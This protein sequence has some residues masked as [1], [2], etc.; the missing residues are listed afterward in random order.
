MSVQDGQMT[1]QDGQMTI[2]GGQIC[3][4][5]CLI[6]LIIKNIGIIFL[7]IEYYLNSDDANEATTQDNHQLHSN[8]KMNL[9]S[10]PLF[11]PVKSQL[12]K[13]TF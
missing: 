3:P 2:Q 7:R 8:F 5:P 4:H 9:T 1:I 13:D 10:K 11:F 6:G 12:H